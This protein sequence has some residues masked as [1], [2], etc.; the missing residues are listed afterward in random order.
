MTEDGAIAL[1]II[2]AY[3]KHKNLPS[4]NSPRYISK[5]YNQKIN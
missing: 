1:T 4:L 5:N 3:K 2:R